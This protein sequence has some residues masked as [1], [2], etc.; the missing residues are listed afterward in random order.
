MRSLQDG[1]VTVNGRQPV[2]FDV[3]NTGPYTINRGDSFGICCN[4]GESYMTETK[5]GWSAT[6]IK[7]GWSVYGQINV[8]GVTTKSERHKRSYW[9]R[10]A[11]G[12]GIGGRKAPVPYGS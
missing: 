4:W 11:D 1:L 7:R 12:N 3:N 8:Y 9:T 6:F 10:T 2:D 5:S